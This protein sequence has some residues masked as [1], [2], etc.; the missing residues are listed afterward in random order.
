MQMLYD[1]LYGYSTAQPLNRE[2]E[3]W[4]MSNSIGNYPPSLSWS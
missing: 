2:K 1:L 4:E 3:K